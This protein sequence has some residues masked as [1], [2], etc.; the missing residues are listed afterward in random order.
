MVLNA[1]EGGAVKRQSKETRVEIDKLVRE[2]A[3]YAPDHPTD[4][5]SFRDACT[6]A[7][8]IKRLREQVRRAR[9]RAE[10]QI[11]LRKRRERYDSAARI[12]EPS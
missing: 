1:S 2:Y 9:R 7:R 3:A 11:E 4:F 5:C 12:R 8:E 6:L 10:R